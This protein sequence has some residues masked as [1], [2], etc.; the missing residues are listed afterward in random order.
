MKEK[1]LPNFKNPPV[2]ETVLGV[3]F[4]PIEKLSAPVYGLYYSKI[5]DEYPDF[6]VHP[7]LSQAVERFDEK[8]GIVPPTINLDIRKTPDVRCWFLEKEGNRL[9]QAQKD[10]FIQNWRKVKE[11]DVYPRYESL[12]PI[13]KREWLRF[14][15][16]LKEEGLSS[17]EVNQCE[18]TYINHLEIGKGWRTFGEIDKITKYWSRESGEFLPVAERGSINLRYQIPERLGRLYI[19]LKPAIRKIDAK[20]IF[21]VEL[22]ARDAPSS[23]KVEDIMGWLDL[24]R[25]WVVKGFADFT[26]NE[27][28]QIWEEK[29]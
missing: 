11:D 29:I 9:L 8:L 22:T 21:Q 2:T 14:C 23:S 6:E 25:E 1:Q 27:L 20:E 16:F 19:N 26:T 3:Q 5:R 12:K 17:P 18:V 4:D 15:D 28:H 13:F 24:G 7:P 10:R